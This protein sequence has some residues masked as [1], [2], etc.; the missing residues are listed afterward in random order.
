MENKNTTLG[1]VAV[2]AIIASLGYLYFTQFAG[3]P[4]VNLKPFENLGYVVAEETAK[5]LNNQGRVLVV[6]EVFEAMKSPNTEAQIKGFKAGLAKS[7]GVQLKEVK[8]FKRPLAD[9]PQHWP[10]GQAARFVNMGDTA[11]A[12]VL[13]VSLPQDLSKEDIAAL[14]ENKNKLILVC[15]QSP[16]LKMLLKEGAVQLAIVNRFPPK[17]TPAGSETPREWFDRVYMAVTPATMDQLP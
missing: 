13:F 5:L 3:A 16:A 15:G 12:T 4:K 2:L 6:S 17:A 10:E 8:E 11:T 1:V 9:D 14:K 7:G